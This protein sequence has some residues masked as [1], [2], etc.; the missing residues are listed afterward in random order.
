MAFVDSYSFSHRFSD[1]KWTDSDTANHQEVVV[2]CHEAS[3]TALTRVFFQFALGC[4]FS[5]NN[6]ASAMAAI[7]EE[8]GEAYCGWEMKRKD[9]KIVE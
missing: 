5:P 6:V 1:E 7:S 4:G 2:Q 9:E 8:Y 3:A